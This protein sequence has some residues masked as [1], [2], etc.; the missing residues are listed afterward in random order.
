MDIEAIAW[1]AQKLQAFAVDNSTMDNALM[2]DRLY[3]MLSAAPTPPE[4][5]NHANLFKWCH[6]GDRQEQRW[7]LMFDDR[8]CGYNLYEVEADAIEGF[9][10]AES[11]GWNCHLFTSV[12]RVAP[13]PP[14]VEPV[15]HV[16]Y[17]M[18]HGHEV[19]KALLFRAGAELPDRTLLYTSPPSPK[20]DWDED[21]NPLNLEA[22]ARD[23]IDLWDSNEDGLVDEHI[24]NLRKFLLEGK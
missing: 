22:A 13:T 6:P 17:E 11:R 10:A 19:R 20:A 1:A 18:H 14:E 5:I 12:P 4:P 7:L 16:Y 21:G 3:A 24:E 8:D 2:M 9:N 15:A 23:C